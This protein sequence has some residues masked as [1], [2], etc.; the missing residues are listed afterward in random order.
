[1]ITLLAAQVGR[2][3][4]LLHLHVAS[5]PFC[6][7]RKRVCYLDV[8]YLTSNFCS[9]GRGHSRCGGSGDD[10]SAHLHRA[11]AVQD[12]ATAVAPHAQG[13]A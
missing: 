8:S 11:G 10:D 1:M 7:T 12:K 4:R 6:V 3:V 5:L 2:L 13:G 9:Y